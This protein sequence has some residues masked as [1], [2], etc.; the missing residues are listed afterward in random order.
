MSLEFYWESHLGFFQGLNRVFELANSL[1]MPNL[2]K[3][4]LKTGS[5]HMDSLW[6]PSSSEHVSAEQKDLVYTNF[7]K[8]FVK[9]LNDHVDEIDNNILTSWIEKMG[10]GIKFVKT[11]PPSQLSSRIHPMNGYMRLSQ[12]IISPSKLRL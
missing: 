10:C 3:E 12:P 1:S 5:G 7:F 6:N 4:V 11:S 8:A 2:K 9:F